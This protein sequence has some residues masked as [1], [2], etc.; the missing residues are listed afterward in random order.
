L[1]YSG[2]P[3]ILILAFNLSALVFPLLPPSTPQK[4]KAKFSPPPENFAQRYLLEVEYYGKEVSEKLPKTKSETSD[5]R[6]FKKIT[7]IISRR[8]NHCNLN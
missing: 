8:K 6:D 2:Y 5:S 4:T 1:A 7:E 3:T